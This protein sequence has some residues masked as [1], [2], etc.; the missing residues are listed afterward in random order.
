MCAADLAQVQRAGMRVVFA[1]GADSECED[2]LQRHLPCS[3]HTVIEVLL[4]GVVGHVHPAEA[5]VRYVDSCGID[6][7]Q[8]ATA[9]EWLYVL[10]AL[11]TEHR[12]AARAQCSA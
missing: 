6:D 2:R 3:R 11:C 8:L 5:V 12:E 10:Y 9:S 7:H 1:D 4:L